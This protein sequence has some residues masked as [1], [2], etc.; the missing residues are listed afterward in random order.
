MSKQQLFLKA[1]NI[2]ASRQRT[3]EEKAEANRAKIYA[4]IP[5]LA[6]MDEKKAE[7]G[8]LAARLAASG[9]KVA[10][11]QNLQQMRDISAR[12]K[13]L[14]GQRG[15]SERDLAPQYTC[16]KCG[17]SGV[18]NGTICSCVKEEI[19]KMRR[20]AIHE[21]GPLTLCSFDNF[22]LAYYPDSMPG[23]EDSPRAIMAENLRDCREYAAYFGPRS[24]NLLLFGN[25]GLGKT[26][27]ALSIA[28]EV[29]D[30]G[31][32]V[33]Y[34][35]AQTAFSQ[36]SAQ[37]FNSDT[38]LFDSMMQAD[39]LIVDDLGTEFV[40]AYVLSKLYELI[41][42]RLVNRPTIYTTNICDDMLLRTKYTEKIASRLLGSCSRMPFLG[43]DVRLQPKL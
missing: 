13:M 43:K 34:I 14:L 4:E 27:L 8:A 20:Q 30:K 21:A 12:R 19:K 15:Y 1:K 3:A 40:D 32:D 36:I 16:E 11:G 10:A 39:L 9:N 31:Y 33:I 38:S 26:H 41:N 25:A 24:E 28:G 17:D 37:R 22:D 18:H 42:G 29:L 35:S 7:A 6:L 2:V 5:E 23:I